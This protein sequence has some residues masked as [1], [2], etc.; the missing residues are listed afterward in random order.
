MNK[1]ANTIILL[2]LFLLPIGSVL[3][4]QE[5]M[6]AQAMRTAFVET[7]Y[8]KFPKS[9]KVKLTPAEEDS[10]SVFWTAL[11]CAGLVP[12]DK[13]HVVKLS[14]N[15]IHI[16][17]LYLDGY[18]FEFRNVPDDP[19]LPLQHILN[20][21]DTQAPFASSYFSY[22]AGDE[23]TAFPGISISYGPEGQSLPLSLHPTM[24]V[25]VIG[26]K[27]EDGFRSTY[28][29]MWHDSEEETN[30]AKHRYYATHGV[31]YE[32]HCP[33]MSSVPQVKAYNPDEYLDRTNTAMSI[34]QHLSYEIRSKEPERAKA[35]YSDTLREMEQY[36]FQTMVNKLYNSAETPN[37][38]TSYEALHLKLQR[39]VK[40][41][42][43]ATNTELQAICH[44]LRKEVDSYPFQYSGWQAEELMR[45]TD[46]IAAAVPNDMKRQVADVRTAISVMRNHTVGIDS[47][48]Q[49]DQEY[50][51]RNFWTVNL[52]PSD[53]G[54][55][56]ITARGEHYSNDSQTG[57]FNV[58]GEA[59]RGFHAENTL[60][61]LRPGRY[62]VSAV[63]RAAEARHSGIHVFAQTGDGTARVMTQKEIPADGDTGGNVWFSALQQLQNLSHGEHI[64]SLDIQKLTANGGQGYGWN[65]IYLDDITVS[66]GTLTYGVT[67]T[68]TSTHS[69]EYVCKWFSA[70]DFIVERIGD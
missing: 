70:C 18:R 26:F 25:R 57:Y 24:N 28:L 35:L 64:Y 11:D 6:H 39:M 41:S 40:L 8:G 62:R 66:N 53:H 15:T 50:L 45:Q 34:A 4:A 27:D 17:P 10:A 12:K 36:H 33:K 7:R 30:D 51:N 9:I 16:G 68:T 49:E 14:D 2:A 67:N 38:K 31:I 3:H 19:T 44:T 58:K 37:L 52:Q 22:T 54:N 48:N 56:A 21:F 32:F 42:Q 69:D 55:T 47:L 63:V 65:R 23:Q 20:A 60:H 29:L 61:N 59:V 13:I 46:A 1:S 5:N 43:T